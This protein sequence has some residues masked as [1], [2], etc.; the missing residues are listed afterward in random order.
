MSCCHKVGGCRHGRTAEDV[1]SGCWKKTS[2]RRR[3]EAAD[4]AGFG[5]LA[6]FRL[7]RLQSP[8]TGRACRGRSDEHA[9]MSI[10]HPRRLDTGVPDRFIGRATARPNSCVA[11]HDLPIGAILRAT[12]RHRHPCR[13]ALARLSWWDPT[14]IRK[15]FSGTIALRMCAVNVGDVRTST[16]CLP[17]AY[18]TEHIMFSTIIASGQPHRRQG[19]A[20]FAD[21]K[22]T[23]GSTPLPKVRRGA[24]RIAICPKSPKPRSAADS[25]VPC[26]PIR[27]KHRTT[28]ARRIAIY[29]CATGAQRDKWPL[30]K[31]FSAIGSALSRPF[32][33]RRQGCG[34]PTD[35]G[36]CNEQNRPRSRQIRVP[37]L[38]TG[39]NP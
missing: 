31:S 36:L 27:R 38:F 15:C 17:A 19:V 18:P 35:D 28:F 11:A 21:K 8:T 34:Q 20:R 14:A 30:W 16:S 3:P 32:R 24:A 26:L 2:V 6:G 12:R 4:G 23:R 29:S 9:R 13:L 25:L 39:G 33:R 7:A 1:R 22:C 37:C 5:G 10:T